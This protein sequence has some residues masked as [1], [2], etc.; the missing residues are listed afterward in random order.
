MR[1][2]ARAFYPHFGFYN[3]SHSSYVRALCPI[4]SQRVPDP[5][6]PTPPPFASLISTDN[7]ALGRRAREA[8][9]HEREGERRRR[10]NDDDDDGG[11]GGGATRRGSSDDDEKD[12]RGAREARARAGR[13]HE[14][15]DDDGEGT[16]TV[17]DRGKDGGES[18]RVARTDR[19]DAS[20][21]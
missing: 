7:A 10:E 15:G 6:V 17:H 18:G 3:R 11:V 1:R 9:A 12:E 2:H 4:I 20:G 5:G 14:G 8:D 16:G 19:D 13:G 21:G